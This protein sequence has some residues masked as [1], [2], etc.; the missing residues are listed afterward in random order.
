MPIRFMV[1][2]PTRYESTDDLRC[3][4]A[5]ECCREAV[6]HQIPLIIVDNSPDE[7][8]RTAFRE[9]GLDEED[10]FSSTSYV[11]VIHWVQGR[12]GAA[13]REG[14]RHASEQLQKYN[15]ADGSSGSGGLTFIAFQEPEKV[16]M[17]RNWKAVASHMTQAKLDICVPRRNNSTF[18]TT[19]PMEQYHSEM[20]ANLHLNA[21]SKQ[22]GFPDNIDWTMGPIMLQTKW[23]NIWQDFNGEMW[24][25]QM[26]PMIRCHHEKGA[27]VGSYEVDFHHPAA[28]KQQEEGVPEWSEKRL[29]QLNLLFDIVGKELRRKEPA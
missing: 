18:Q 20:F 11:T 27:A 6:Q 25:A 19:Y 7:K 16:D 10:S 29:V 3:A 4:L 8:V 22:V 2:V 15:T 17:I 13:L 21:I 9:A 23:A 14:I 26:I 28:M 24:D 5:L 12:K 1:V